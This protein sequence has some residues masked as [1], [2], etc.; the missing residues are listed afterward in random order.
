MELG[1]DAV[2]VGY[3]EPFDAWVMDATDVRGVD[4]VV[5]SVGAAT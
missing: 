1:V 4:L 3:D 2:K 5:D